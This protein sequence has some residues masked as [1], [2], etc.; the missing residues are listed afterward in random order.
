M[1]RK[2]NFLSKPNYTMLEG[3]SFLTKQFPGE[4]GGSSRQITYK[5]INL[6]Q[7]DSSSKN[8]ITVRKR[9][10]GK[11]MF[12]QACVKN[13]VHR[14]VYTRVPSAQCMLGYIPL[15]DTSL[16][17]TPSPPSRPPPP[18]ATAADATHPTGMHSFICY[19]HIQFLHNC[20][21]MLDVLIRLSTWNVLMTIFQ[22]SKTWRKLFE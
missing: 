13:S 10:C 17:D 16:A 12:S 4:A 7:V 8:I 2:I 1:R 22:F 5:L 14:G 11:I 20:A 21:R 15:A 9:N 18:T 3:M 6:I 19:F